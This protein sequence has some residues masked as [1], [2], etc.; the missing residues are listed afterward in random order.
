MNE[1]DQIIH[2]QKSGP[3]A[4]TQLAPLARVSGAV[5]V[6]AL[7]LCALLAGCA[8]S[9]SELAA[10]PKSRHSD[11]ALD[12][13][14]RRLRCIAHYAAAGSTD[15]ARVR[16]ARENW[17]LGTAIGGAVSAAVASIWLAADPENSGDAQRIT[18]VSTA[19]VSAAAAIIQL[20]TR[21]DLEGRY[22][23]LLESQ[24][25]IEDYLEIESDPLL[26]ADE[27]DRQAQGE[28][29]TAAAR[30]GQRL[31]DA[32]RRI[33]NVL[34]EQFGGP[35]RDEIIPRCVDTLGGGSR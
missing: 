12:Q 27:R 20:L 7:T 25:T 26:A 10:N 35:W 16:R 32:E 9:L 17:L 8:A 21:H 33:V 34:D 29:P 23:D 11:A 6:T 24:A 2:E 14:G 28:G 13:N 5:R 15:I 3:V 30:P 18:T 22:K 4:A 31:E 1:D 19:G